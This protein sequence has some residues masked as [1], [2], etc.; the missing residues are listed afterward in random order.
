MC[1]FLCLE[2]TVRLRLGD[3]VLKLAL[4]LH[5]SRKN[6]VVEPSLLHVKLFV[7]SLSVLVELLLNLICIFQNTTD[8]DQ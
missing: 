4:I 8:Q 3:S 5:S 6:R 1:L 2:D 7:L